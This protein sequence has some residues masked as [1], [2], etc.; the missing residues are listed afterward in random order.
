MFSGDGANGE[1]ELEV[2]NETSVDDDEAE[3]DEEDS[4]DG[5]TVQVHDFDDDDDDDQDEEGDEG[6]AVSNFVW[7]AC[8]PAKLNQSFSME[9]IEEE[10][11]EDGLEVLIG[12]YKN[13]HGIDGLTGFTG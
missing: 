2:Q 1:G 8:Y 10:C 12:I 3:G 9:V 13:L 11:E 5:G 4:G 6:V 7:Q